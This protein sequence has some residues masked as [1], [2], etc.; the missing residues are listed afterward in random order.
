MPASRPAARSSRRRSRI[1]GFTAAIVLVMAA[2]I[3]AIALANKGENATPGASAAT[4]AEGVAATWVDRQVS[5][6]AIVACDRVMCGALRKRGFP[7]GQLEVVEK[8]SS[9]PVHAQVVIETPVVRGLFGSSLATNVAPETLVTF[10]SGRRQIAVRIIAPAG[11]AAYRAHLAKDE[12]ARRS[13]GRNLLGSGGVIA[14]PQAKKQILA[15]QV[16]M[17]LLVVLTALA[18]AESRI[19]IVSFGPLATGQSASLPLRSVFLGAGSAGFG[20]LQRVV[21]QQ[22]SPFRRSFDHTV[23]VGGKKL[24]KIVFSAPSPLELGAP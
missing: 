19:D 7:G 6:N 22:P 20:L 13:A 5:H 10:G 8:S 4:S 18:G 11:A 21:D 23:Q 15:G 16:D 9:Y 14:S 17:R 12:Q 24:L 2:A 3:T 1:A